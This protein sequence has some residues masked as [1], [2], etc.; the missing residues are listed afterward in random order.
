MV[1]GF[2]IRGYALSILVG[3]LVAVLWSQRR[4]AARGGNREVVLDVALA[5]V[6]AGI[7]GGRLYH[8]AT[9]WRTYWAVS[10]THLTLPT[11]YSV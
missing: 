11:I 9:D 7:I 8:L 10:Y 3:I 5:A 6:P 1:G 4:Y 2:P